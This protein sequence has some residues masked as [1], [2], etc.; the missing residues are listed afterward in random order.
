MPAAFSTLEEAER[1]FDQYFNALNHFL[2]S[3]E[4]TDKEG[5]PAPDHVLHSITIQHSQRVKEFED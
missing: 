1:V 4:V 3:A 2:Q 5:Q